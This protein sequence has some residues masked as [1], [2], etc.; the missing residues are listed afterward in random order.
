MTRTEFE[1]AW[2]SYF[3]E[4]LLNSLAGEEGGEEGDESGEPPSADKLNWWEQFRAE[5]MP[6]ILAKHP[7]PFPETREANRW[8]P[9]L[10]EIIHSQSR[11]D[12]PIAALAKMHLERH[13]AVYIGAPPPFPHAT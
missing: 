13:A 4:T 11:R 8:P 9:G 12:H 7:A 10:T 2:R 6:G 1:K 5:A 3:L